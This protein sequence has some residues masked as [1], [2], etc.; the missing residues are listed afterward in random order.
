M[1]TAHLPASY[2]LTR[3]MLQFPGLAFDFRFHPV[4]MGAGLLA[5]IAPDFDLLY[6]FLI[7]HR[8]HL[9][10]SYWTHM[11]FFWTTIFA[12]LF[13]LNFRLRSRRLF[14]LSLI[15]YTSIM[16]HLFL[17]TIV[18]KIEWLWPL[19][20]HAFYF[21]EVPARFSPWILNF[22]LHWSFGFE[23]AIWGLAVWVFRQ[24]EAGREEA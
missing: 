14:N 12:A 6:F 1:L 18:G 15:I 4:L 11:P 22:I 3:K 10:H 17:D 7:D 8:Q 19:S 9:H 21:F 2:L 20:D 5:G 13:L 16:L 24:P 23:L